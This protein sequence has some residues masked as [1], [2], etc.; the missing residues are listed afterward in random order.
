MTFYSVSLWLKTY[1]VKK[2]PGSSFS[3]KRRTWL[4][5]FWSEHTAIRKPEGS[6]NGFKNLQKRTSELVL[7]QLVF[8]RG[9]GSKTTWEVTLQQV[10]R[11][12]F[13]WFPHKLRTTRLERRASWGGRT[14]RSFRDRFSFSSSC[15]SH[16]S[17]GT[18]CRIKHGGVRRSAWK[19][20]SKSEC[21]IC[22]WR[23]KALKPHA[24]SQL[25]VL[26]IPSVHDEPGSERCIQIVWWWAFGFCQLMSGCPPSPSSSSV[27]LSPP[28]DTPCPPS[29]QRFS[30]E[31][32]LLSDHQGFPSVT[33]FRRSFQSYSM[34][35]LPRCPFL[36]VD[37][38]VEPC[39]VQML[40]LLVEVFLSGGA[41]L[42][43]GL[44]SVQMVQSDVLALLRDQDSDGT[45]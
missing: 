16:S 7:V 3:P 12:V 39:S 31:P 9:V 19:C 23:T 33:A 26:Q 35:R 14:F 37:V 10:K 32:R 2:S 29:P 42:S 30:P 18:S 22:S 41:V 38:P 40:Y 28:P 8:F 43:T 34:V 20:S 15:S 21:F 11:V 4:S 44:S 5:D 36:G 25:K 24:S 6:F 13:T 27:P 17:S 1:C 45:E